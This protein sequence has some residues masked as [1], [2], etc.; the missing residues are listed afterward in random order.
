MT[1]NE[2]HQIAALILFV[3]GM[4]LCGFAVGIFFGEG[5][6]FLFVGLPLLAIGIHGM[7]TN[8]K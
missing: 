8:P 5:V 7:V 3:I 2:D 6:G 1:R 4:I